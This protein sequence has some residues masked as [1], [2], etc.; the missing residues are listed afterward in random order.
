MSLI[1]VTNGYSSS[2]LTARTRSSRR[3]TTLKNVS[4]SSYGAHVLALVLPLP[5]P[6]IPHH[7]QI[8]P[9]RIP[10]SDLILGVPQPPVS[11]VCRLGG[12]HQAQTLQ[13]RTLRKP[14]LKFPASRK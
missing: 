12:V 8:Q 6:L 11:G 14:L 13:K 3:A 10:L 5:P 7:T 1:S 9:Q 2:G 4:S